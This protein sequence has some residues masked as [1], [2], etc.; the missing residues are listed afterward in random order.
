MSYSSSS[1][2]HAAAA[3][4][5]ISLTVG[6]NVHIAASF[7]IRNKLHV[8]DNGGAVQRPSIAGGLALAG[9]IAMRTPFRPPGVVHKLF[10]VQAFGKFP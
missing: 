4:A 1:E 7:G 6:D 5:V 3:A 2:L 10:R 8:L 9:K